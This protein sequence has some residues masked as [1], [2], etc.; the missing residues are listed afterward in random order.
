MEKKIFEGFWPYMGVAFGS[1]EL[2]SESREGKN[3]TGKSTWRRDIRCFSGQ[4]FV[5]SIIATV[6]TFQTTILCG[7]TS[8]Y[9]LHGRDGQKNRRDLHT[10]RHRGIKHDFPFINIRKVPMEVLKTEGEGRGFQ[11]SQGTLQMLMNDKKSCLI[12]IIAQIQQNIAKM[13]KI[14]A[15]YIL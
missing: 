15:H 10:T 1:G 3:N 2:K 5:D 4:C 9:I 6:S 8:F 14:L 12:A 7:Y 11:P 13:K